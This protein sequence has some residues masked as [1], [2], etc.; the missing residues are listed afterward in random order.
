MNP[1]LI[2]RSVV[3]RPPAGGAPMKKKSKGREIA[4]LV[5]ACLGCGWESAPVSG[6]AAWKKI[7]KHECPKA[8]F[9]GSGDRQG[10]MVGP[11]FNF[12][13]SEGGGR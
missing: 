1:N 5:H 9:E 7:P 13:E 10:A 2:L 4:G 3:I 8:R 6:P 11:R 12:R